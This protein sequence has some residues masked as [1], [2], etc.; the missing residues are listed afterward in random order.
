MDEPAPVEVER[1]RAKMLEQAER[2]AHL[3]VDKAGLEAE[4]Q[5][6]RELLREFAEAQEKYD[7]AGAAYFA[8]YGAEHE[9]ECPEDDTCECELVVSLNETWRRLALA[10][11]NTRDYLR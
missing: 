10:G 11:Q 5:R 6:L 4:N 2:H 3:G 9:E 7:E 8:H 1:L